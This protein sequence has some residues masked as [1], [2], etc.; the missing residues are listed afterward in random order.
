MKKNIRHLIQISLIL[1][2]GQV[3]AQDPN[4]SMFYNVPTYYNPAMTAINNGL[5]VRSNYRNLWTPIVSKLNTYSAACE[6]EAVN[7]IGFGLL[8]SSDLAGEGLLR[9]NKATASYMYRPIEGENLLLQFGLSGS[10]VNKFIDWDRLVFSD[11][12]DEVHGQVRP[13]AFLSPNYN[14]VS[15]ADFNAGVALR[16]NIRP[17]RTGRIYRKMNGTAGLAFHHLNEPQDAFL[18]EGASLLPIKTVAHSGFNILLQQSILSTAMIYEHQGRFQTFSAGFNVAYST[19]FGGVWFRK[20]SSL[21]KTQFDS[22]I[23]TGGANLKL[24][25][26]SKMRVSYSFDLTVSR[27]HTASI[28]S[29]EVSLIFFFDDKVLFRKYR[30]QKKIKDRYKCPEGFDGY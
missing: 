15:Y 6:I 19:L 7:K 20:G 21:R 4:F 29:H 11:Q 1:V 26:K 8:L 12:L 18:G 3:Q 23:L 14:T 17:G 22:V 30:E 13:S 27:L 16:F 25:D 9:T 5:T 2:L 10:Y 28:G 24:S